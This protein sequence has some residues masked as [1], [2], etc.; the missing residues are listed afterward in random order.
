MAGTLLI[1]QR[2]LKIKTLAVLYNARVGK[3]VKF[4]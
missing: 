4:W 3:L 2:P 1:F